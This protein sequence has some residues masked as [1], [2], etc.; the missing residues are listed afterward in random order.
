MK[1]TVMK[2]GGTS[3]EGATAFKNAANLICDR[4]S[5]RPVVVVSAMAGFTDA[6]IE[7]VK[8]AT[9]DA[10]TALSLLVK[11]FDR[12]YRVIDALLV[13]EAETMKSFIAGSCDELAKLLERA[14][15][16]LNE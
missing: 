13:N 9:S 8:A 16:E 1:S 10:N 4:Q 12:H 14:N 3:V 15:T 6:L 7:S 2:F 11:H 5:V